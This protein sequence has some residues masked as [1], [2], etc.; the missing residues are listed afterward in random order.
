MMLRV[1]IFSLL[2]I[3]FLTP[4]GLLAGSRE[5]VVKLEVVGYPTEELVSQDIIDN[6]L[7]NQLGNLSVEPMILNE[8]TLEDGLVLTSTISKNLDSAI[9]VSVF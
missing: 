1:F 6:F 2:T 5:I 9:V 7:D 8:L 4:Q 3:F